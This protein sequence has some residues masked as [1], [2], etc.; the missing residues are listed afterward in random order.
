MLL[1]GRH[2]TWGFKLCFLYLRNVRGF[3]WNH[4]CVYRIYCELALNLR[5]KPRKRLY[6][7]KPEAL[8][9]PLAINQLWSMDFMHDQLVDG[10]R[11]RTFNVIDDFNR[12]GLGIEVDFLL[13]VARVIRALDQ[14]SNG[15][16]FPAASAAIM[17]RNISATC[18]P[19]GRKSEVSACN[20]RRSP[21]A[22]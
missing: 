21:W 11:F 17:A 5:I 13:P 2:S 20:L 7:K 8:S 12:E 3:G 10:R 9:V 16:G 19:A 4:K 18:W 15:A 22:R 1:T 6:R 14:S